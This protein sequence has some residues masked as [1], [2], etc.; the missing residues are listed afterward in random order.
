MHI[1]YE[2]FIKMLAD[3]YAEFN[4]NSYEDSEHAYMC[5]FLE[6]SYYYE[7]EQILQNM[8]SIM[9]N[10]FGITAEPEY[11][12]EYRMELLAVIS[13]IQGVNSCPFQ[14]A[15]Y[16]KRGLVPP[17]GKNHVEVNKF[18]EQWL[19]EG[20]LFYTYEKVEA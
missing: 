20:G 13:R 10:R 16:Y 1:T 3:S 15:E 7:E 5:L 8:R 2:H 12:K 18:R 11:F 6:N 14:F 9:F 4:R 17:K 19:R